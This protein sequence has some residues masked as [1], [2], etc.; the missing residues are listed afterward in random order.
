MKSRKRSVASSGQPE[1]VV[2]F[3]DR[4]LGS[5]FVAEALRSQGH[6]VV[7]HEQR[8]A[9]GALDEEWLAEAGRSGWVVLSKDTRIQYRELERR[10]LERA[11]VRAF[12]LVSANLTGPQ[13]AEV[14]KRALPG[15]I[16]LIRGRRPPFIARVYRNGQVKPLRG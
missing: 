14:I 7:T 5:H 2:F 15:M 9:A 10:A 11:M 8:F 6:E 12:I 13:M 1:R 4:S 3:I 16:L